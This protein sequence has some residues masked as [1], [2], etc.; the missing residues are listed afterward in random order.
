MRRVL[1]HVWGEKGEVYVG[2]SITLYKDPEV[3]W[4]GVKTG[5]IRISHMS[6]ID[7]PMTMAL[8]ATRANRKPFTVQPLK[9]E[10]T[11]EP[12]KE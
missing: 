5:G 2:R 9:I 6:H 7:K 10:Q 3:M 4:G 11:P 8:T 12:K 1:V